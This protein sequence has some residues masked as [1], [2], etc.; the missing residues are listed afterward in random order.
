VAKIGPKIKTFFI[1][2]KVYCYVN[3]YGE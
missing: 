1:E 2:A 3:F